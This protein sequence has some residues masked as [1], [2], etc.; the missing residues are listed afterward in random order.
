MSDN[1][2]MALYFI[3]EFY[4]AKKSNL[5]G[6]VTPTFRFKPPSKPEL[7]FDEYMTYIDRFV[8]SVN[9]IV[10]GISSDDDIIFKVDYTIETLSVKGGLGIE[11]KGYAIVKLL[12]DQ[13][14]YVEIINNTSELDPVK[15]ANFRA[16]LNKN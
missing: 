3:R 14:D 9:L 8:N 5:V 6:M 4:R 16:E 1:T 11:I 12:D 13:I 15:I 2:E 7:T 10:H